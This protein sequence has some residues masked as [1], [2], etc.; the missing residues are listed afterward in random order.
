[1]N[2]SIAIRH[3]RRT[4]AEPERKII[5]A[6]LPRIGWP[7]TLVAQGGFIHEQAIEEDFDPSRHEDAFLSPVRD[8]SGN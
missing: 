1:V 5:D 8:V 2:G 4:R 6:G 7:E 3:Q